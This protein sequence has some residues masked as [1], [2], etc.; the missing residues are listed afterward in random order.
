MSSAK[1]HVGILTGATLMVALAFALALIYFMQ[2]SPSARVASAQ[3]SDQAPVITSLSNPTC[4]SVEVA[5][6]EV[7]GIDD[8]WIYSVETDGSGARFQEAIPWG[9]DYGA[10]FTKVEDLEP[11]AEYWFAVVGALSPTPEGPDASFSWSHWH[12]ITT[13]GGGAPTMPFNLQSVIRT[14]SS[15]TWDWDFDADGDAFEYSHRMAGT[16]NWSSSTRTT[17]NSTTVFGLSDDTTYEFRVRAVGCGGS[18]AYATDTATTAVAPTPTPTATPTATPTPTPTATATFA[19]TPTFT[20]TPVPDPGPSNLHADQRTAVTVTLDWN[21]ISGT[22]EYESAYRRIGYGFTD[23]GTTTDSERKFEGLAPKTEYEFRVRAMVNGVWTAYSTVRLETT[24]VQYILESGTHEIHSGGTAYIIGGL[25]GRGGD[26]IYD[27]DEDD[28]AYRS[29]SYGGGGGAGGVVVVNIT[30]TGD[31]IVTIGENGARGS[32]ADTTGYITHPA[33]DGEDGGDTSLSG[34]GINL[35]AP[36]GEGGHKGN[37]NGTNRVGGST[38]AFY[39]VPS[40]KTGADGPYRSSYTWYAGKN[41][42]PA[43]VGSY[44]PMQSWRGFIAVGHTS[45]GS[46]TYHRSIDT[47]QASLSVSP[48]GGVVTTYLRSA[49]VVVVY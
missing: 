10:S 23:S 49:R 26:A 35:T 8:Y 47:D 33:S 20:P 1:R 7:N 46:A 42:A 28:I 32:N 45:G 31:Y 12:V 38:P 48:V 15:I 9:S 27:T 22:T 6:Q 4:G 30:T 37:G 34:H 25:G 18:S 5:W 13:L 36:G 21:Y 3:N 17:E 24:N 14:A 44:S 43:A 39:G 40:V 19:P 29:A 41:P 2:D 11:G 16:E